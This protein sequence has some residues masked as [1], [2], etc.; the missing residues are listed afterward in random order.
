MLTRLQVGGDAGRQGFAVGVLLLDD[1][2]LLAVRSAGGLPGYGVSGR[3]FADY[4]KRAF[5]SEPEPGL[6]QRNLALVHLVFGEVALEKDQRI[7][8][9]HALS[10]TDDRYVCKVL[11]VSYLF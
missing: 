8:G 4:P 9:Q 11:S 3:R 10:C 2:S 5:T 1:Q 6:I 7:M